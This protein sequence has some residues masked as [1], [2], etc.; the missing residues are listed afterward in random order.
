[1]WQRSSTHVSGNRA[2]DSEGVGAYR[3]NEPAAEKTDFHVAAIDSI[4]SVPVPNRRHTPSSPVGWNVA[5]NQYIHSG[6]QRLSS[7]AAARPQSLQTNLE[8]LVRVFSSLKPDSDEK[9][10]S[11]INF[12]SG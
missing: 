9:S 7:L 8:S 5:A 11:Q 3:R 2:A 6:S 12:S 4:N 10:S 1:M